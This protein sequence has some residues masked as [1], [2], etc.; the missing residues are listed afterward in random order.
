MIC[1]MFRHPCA[2]QLF[3]NSEAGRYDRIVERFR[4]TPAKSPDDVV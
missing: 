3:A 4:T 1:G 2:F